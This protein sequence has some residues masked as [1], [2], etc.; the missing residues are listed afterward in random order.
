MGMIQKKWFSVETLKDGSV[1]KFCEVEAKGRNGSVIRFYEA[2]DAADACSQAKDWH[3][4]RKAR[5][6]KL[7]ADK[8]E[9]LRATGV[10]FRCRKKPMVNASWCAECRD[11]ANLL[12]RQLRR[13]ERPVSV[14]RLS[15][16]DAFAREKERNAR[17]RERMKEKHGSAAVYRYVI[18]LEKFDRLGPGAFRAWLVSKIPAVQTDSEPLSESEKEALTDS[19]A[20]R[21]DGEPMIPHATVMS[22]AAE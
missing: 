18:L 16:D 5:D 1:G 13:G 12:R 17:D 9:E 8:R 7:R 2:I 14:P 6:N 19:R 10:C 22:E 4:R 21:H 11:K 20:R 3:S 15:A